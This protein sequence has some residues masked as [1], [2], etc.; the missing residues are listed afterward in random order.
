LV[1]ALIATT[2]LVTGILTAMTSIA[3]AIRQNSSANRITRASEIAAQVRAGLHSQGSQRLLAGTGPLQAAH[4]AANYTYAFGINQLAPAG[5]SAP[6]AINL[7]AFELTAPVALKVV[8][9]YSTSDGPPPTGP[10]RR[11]LVDFQ[12]MDGGTIVSDK[13]AVIVAWDEALGPKYVLQY[14]T[15]LAPTANNGQFAY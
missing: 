12:Q 10:F 6:F 7:D 5:L 9:G 8:P 3:M 11:T 4:L 1:E 2:L 15:V 13:I 14:E